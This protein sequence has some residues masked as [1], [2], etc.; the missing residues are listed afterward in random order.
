ME[1]KYYN[2][3]I[4]LIKEHKKFP[5]LENILEDIANDV[6]LKSQNV[7][8]SIDNE[9]VIV[10]YLNKVISCSIIT[11]SKR[12]GYK[13]RVSTTLPQDINLVNTQIFEDF[14]E[15]DT[16]SNAEMSSLILEQENFEFDENETLDLEINSSNEK[17]IDQEE[18]PVDIALVDKMIN[19]VEIEETQIDEI[20]SFDI[21]EEISVESNEDVFQEDIA[22]TMEISENNS[23]EEAIK[24][25]NESFD[26]EIIES[27]SLDT[28]LDEENLLMEDISFELPMETED[29]FIIKEEEASFVEEEIINTEVIENEENIYIET[30]NTENDLAF[31]KFSNFEINNVEKDSIEIESSISSLKDF[32]IS[33]PEKNIF[34]ICDL[35]FKQKMPIKNISERLEI[36][37]EIVLKTLNEIVTTIKV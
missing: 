34:K 13:K 3:I 11:V 14:N 15:E 37:E 24:D 25:C 20:D 26:S 1:N 16:Q 4:S 30:E 27:M 32:A 33:N 6:S 5:G 35:K 2:L 8:N 10:D 28:N 36:P 18:I 23:L 21:I 31:P 7:L 22:E 19:G 12:M 29:E 17:N 9:D